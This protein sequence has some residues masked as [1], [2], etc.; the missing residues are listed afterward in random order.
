MTTGSTNVYISKICLLWR[1][2]YK[3]SIFCKFQ[4]CC[5]TWGLYRDLRFVFIRNLACPVR[6]GSLII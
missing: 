2:N 3:N 5:F 6:I 1:V 4:V